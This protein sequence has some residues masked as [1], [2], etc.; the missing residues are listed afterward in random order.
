M[1]HKLNY[2]NQSMTE[3]V[4][5]ERNK[6]YGAFLL[7]NL[8][9][10]H[11]LKALLI[12]LSSFILITSAPLIIRHLGLL[13][14]NETALI[15]TT[16]FILHAPPSLNPLKPP[17]PPPPQVE[18]VKSPVT[19]SEEMEAVEKENVTEPPPPKIDEPDKQKTEA[20]P[21]NEPPISAD[22]LSNGGGISGDGK[23]WNKV[24]IPPEFNGGED[25]YFQFMGDNLIYPD[26][27]KGQGIEGI[28]RIYY[29]V[30]Q[31]GAVE[32]ARIIKSSGNKNLDAEALRLIRIQPNYKPG[33]QNG[34]PVKVSCVTEI[35]FK[36]D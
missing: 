6:S 16:I 5:E 19:K 35:E 32:N 1:A 25:A 26:Y 30:N 24:E 31:Q 36:L 11:L 22:E 14:D 28:A 17:Q 4:F 20:P 8:Y 10:R 15:D 7:R 34:K 13:G 27:E 18:E 21:S 3:I 2:F 29:V 23:I 9:R 12:T 33:R